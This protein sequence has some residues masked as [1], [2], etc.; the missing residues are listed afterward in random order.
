[1]FVYLDSIDR[2][3]EIETNVCNIS[4]IDRVADELYPL[5]DEYDEPELTRK[6]FVH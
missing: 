2:F 4:Y 6:A 1:M 5:L 3:S